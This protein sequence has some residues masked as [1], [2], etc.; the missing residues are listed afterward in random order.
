MSPE[1]ETAGPHGLPA[2]QY[3]VRYCTENFLVSVVTVMQEVFIMR[4]FFSL[5]QVFTTK[6]LAVM[7]MLLA[8]RVILGLPFLTI[9]LTPQFKLISFAYLC[10]AA[11]AMLY[12]PW[13]ALA[14]GFAG[15]TLGYFATMGSGGGYMPLFAISEMVTGFIFAAFLYDPAR[16]SSGSRQPENRPDV[17]LTRVLPAWALNLILVVLGLNSLWLML[18]Y[19]SSAGSVFTLVRFGSN[20]AQFPLHVALTYFVLRAIRRMRS[21]TD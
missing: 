20:L 4:G 9:Y 5:K 13:A 10:D 1:N 17:R 3:C 12:G 15:D 19:G 8:I 6:H 7:A 18:L 11:T 2:V 21:Y 16:L 14:F